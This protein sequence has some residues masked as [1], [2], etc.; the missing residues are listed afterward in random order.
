V[1]NI[2]RGMVV[3]IWTIPPIFHGCLLTTSDRSASQS[4]S[5]NQAQHIARDV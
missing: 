5:F 2:D 3:R 4:A 1:T